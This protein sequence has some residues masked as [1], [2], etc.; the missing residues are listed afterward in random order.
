[1]HEG[2]IL[3]CQNLLIYILLSS[4][5]ISNKVRPIKSH[6]GMMKMDDVNH[7]HSS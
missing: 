1:M 4:Q 7:Y 6:N 3:S 2:N 5:L